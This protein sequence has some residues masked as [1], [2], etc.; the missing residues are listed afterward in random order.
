M[1]VSLRFDTV[2]QG[3]SAP[4]YCDAQLPEPSGHSGTYSSVL[5]D[6]SD[7]KRSELEE[8]QGHHDVRKCS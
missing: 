7:E 4:Q 1:V 2:L 3:V 8:R 6:M 5:R